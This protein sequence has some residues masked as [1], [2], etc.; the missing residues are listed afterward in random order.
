MADLAPK[1]HRLESIVAQGLCIGCGLCQSIAGKANVRMAMNGEGGERPMV[2][3]TVD[4]PALRLINAVCPGI[5]CVGYVHQDSP[6]AEEAPP[7]VHPI[8]YRPV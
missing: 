5:H 1:V 4:E 7:E 3:G 2:I 6:E 8:W